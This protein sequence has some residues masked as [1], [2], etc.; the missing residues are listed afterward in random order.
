MHVPT[1][2]IF[3]NWKQYTKL[4]L[5][6]YNKF[7]LL[8]HVLHVLVIKQFQATLTLQEENQLTS[9]SKYWLP[10]SFCICIDAYLIKIYDCHIL[11]S[12]V[13][14][15]LFKMSNKS[16]RSNKPSNY[17]KLS[18][19]TESRYSLSLSLSHYE[20][21]LSLSVSLTHFNE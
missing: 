1:I 6:R 15:R 10:C 8:V 20:F 3:I 19:L 4:M 9:H 16:S 14:S 17:S 5:I 7:Y 11:F 12:T 18:I 2:Y 21:P 13:Y